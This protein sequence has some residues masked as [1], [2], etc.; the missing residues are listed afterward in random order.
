MTQVYLL[1]R[2][3]FCIRAYESLDEARSEALRIVSEAYAECVANGSK[4]PTSCPTTWDEIH[5]WNSH[6]KCESERRAYV[7]WVDLVPGGQQVPSEQNSRNSEG[8]LTAWQDRML[9]MCARRLATHGRVIIWNPKLGQVFMYGAAG[10][11]RI[12]R[13]IN[14][15]IGF[16][17]P[18]Y[19]DTYD[20]SWV[21]MTEK[22]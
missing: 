10:D 5:N 18:G 22:G 13:G 17:G 21:L 9:F 1:W 11:V 14:G 19:F 2:G 8:E 4:P 15:T 6:W 16:G 3:N 12:S 20:D 7:T